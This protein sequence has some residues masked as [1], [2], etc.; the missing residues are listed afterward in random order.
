MQNKILLIFYFAQASKNVY[1]TIMCSS[2]FFSLACIIKHR[3][4]VHLFGN[5]F[6]HNVGIGRLE[7]YN[8]LKPYEPNLPLALIN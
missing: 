8:S 7:M 6:E 5:R 1:V 2:Y 4:S 3:C